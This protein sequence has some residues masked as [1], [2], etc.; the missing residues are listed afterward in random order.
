[1]SVG[2]VLLLTAE[3]NELDKEVNKAGKDDGWKKRPLEE[4]WDVLY[5]IPRGLFHTP[6]NINALEHAFKSSAGLF[7]VSDGQCLLAEVNLVWGAHMASTYVAQQKTVAD[8]TG[9]VL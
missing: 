4:K 1:M 6:Q 7:F 3:K 2:T 5:W 9:G 8:L